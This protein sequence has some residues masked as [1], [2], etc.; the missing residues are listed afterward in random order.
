SDTREDVK[1]VLFSLNNLDLCKDVE[2]KANEYCIVKNRELAVC[3]SGKKRRKGDEKLPKFKEKANRKPSRIE[4]DVFDFSDSNLRKAE[5]CKSCPVTKP[6]FFCGSD[7]A[8]YSSLCRLQ[9][10]NCVHNTHVQAVCEGFCPCKAEKNHFELAKEIRTR[11]R[12]NKFL[13]SMKEEKRNQ[14]LDKFRNTIA[15]N[16]VRNK[17]ISDF[18]TKYKE[19]PCSKSELQVM[20][21]RLLDWFSV[22]SS[23]QKRMHKTSKKKLI[24]C[25]A[26]IGW[27]F[28]HFDVDNDMKLSLKKELYDLEHDKR[29]KCLKQYLDGCDEDRDTFLQPYEWCSC[30]QK[31]SKYSSY[32]QVVKNEFLG[33]PCTTAIKHSKKG[34]LG[35]YRPQCDSDGNFEPLQCNP[36]TGE[37]WCVDKT[38]LEFS[39]TRRKG[40]PDCE[41]LLNRAQKRTKFEDDDTEDDSDDED[42][43]SSGD[44]PNTL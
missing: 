11:K 5:R 34:L 7:N 23:D 12:M 27:M 22:V 31:K 29:E 19:K 44:G 26:E 3:V 40:K 32:N 24:G 35:A 36:S 33:E 4:S 37:C 38:G 39:N 28:H 16:G 2:C 43:S 9:F 17:H 13:N 25:K 21:T 8:T 42:I 10:H 30:F 14:K 1:D 20:G 15:T 18:N 41:G 6:N